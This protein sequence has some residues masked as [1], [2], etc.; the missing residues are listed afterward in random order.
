MLSQNLDKIDW[1]EISSNPSEG[2]ADLLLEKNPNHPDRLLHTNEIV[3]ERTFMNE[4]DR[5]TQFVLDIPLKLAENMSWDILTSSGFQD[6]LE[7]CDDYFWNHLSY[8]RNN[9]AVDLLFKNVDNIAIDCF[10]ANNNDRAVKYLLENIDE[11]EGDMDWTRFSHNENDLAVNYL[12]QHP[13]K[14]VWDYFSAN[15]NDMAVDYLFQHPDKI[16][17]S[18]LCCNNNDKAI[19]YVLQQPDKID[20]DKLCENDNDRAIDLLELEENRD[21]INWTFLSFNTN[22]RLWSKSD[23]FLK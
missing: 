9:A 5:V 23:Y 1:E 18:D 13:D 8:N 7:K 4:N 3:V 6:F 14:I 15:G 17:W 21:R 19:N 2:A 11:L 20:W 22:E 12:L 10:C 16:V